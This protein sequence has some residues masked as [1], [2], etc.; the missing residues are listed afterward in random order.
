[1]VAFLDREG[2]Q[3]SRVA[4]NG[5]GGTALHDVARSSWAAAISAGLPAAHHDIARAD[6][7]VT[8]H[9]YSCQNT[10][11]QPK[12]QLSATQA[13]TAVDSTLPSLAGVF[14]IRGLIRRALRLLQLSARCCL[15][16]PPVPY[17]FLF[18]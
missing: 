10:N 3:K 9:R 18:G 16:L 2:D 12:F 15:T 7:H 6:V 13:R 11:L 1:M 14:L 8:K 17:T 4:L 5:S